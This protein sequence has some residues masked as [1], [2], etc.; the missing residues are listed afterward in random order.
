MQVKVFLIASIFLV[1]VTVAAQN[2]QQDFSKVEIKATKIG[3]KFYTLEGQGD[4]IGAQE[5]VAARPTADFD[6]KV[7]QAGTTAERF[8]NQLYAELGG[9]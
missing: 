8:I 1:A 9:K 7:E 6:S 3:D 4:T 2:A 5:I